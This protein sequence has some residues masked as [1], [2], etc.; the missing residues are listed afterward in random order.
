MTDEV[1]RFDCPNCGAKNGQL[2]R[3]HMCPIPAEWLEKLSKAGT[4][5]GKKFAEHP[6]NGDSHGRTA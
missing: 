5:W 2:S 6:Q 1:N 4:V 3:S